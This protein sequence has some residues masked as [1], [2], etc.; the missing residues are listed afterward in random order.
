MMHSSDVTAGTIKS[1]VR[2]AEN[3]NARVM[4]PKQSEE[5][6]DVASRSQGMSKETFSTLEAVQIS[7]E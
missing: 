4:G 2:K 1:Q 6:K 7:R 3:M 5:H